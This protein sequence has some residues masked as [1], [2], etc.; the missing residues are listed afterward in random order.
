MQYVIFSVWFT[1]LHSVMYTLAG[2]IALKFSREIYEGENRNVDFIRDMK[3]PAESRH[4]QRWFFPAQLVRGML[5]SLAVYPVLGAL[6]EAAF[7]LRFAFMF[8]LLFICTHI[9]SAAPCPDNIEGWVYL[10]EKYLRKNTFW[11]FQL[12]MIIYSVLV[13]AAAAWLLL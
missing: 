4:V 10:K 1:V 2:M 5:I 6:G 8:A 13:S 11:K 9:G 12:E 3:N 7:L